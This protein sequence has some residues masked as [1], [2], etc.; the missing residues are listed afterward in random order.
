MN[1]EIL[2]QA[3]AGLSDSE[4][5]KL[6]QKVSAAR[7]SEHVA[8]IKAAFSGLVVPANVDALIDR[9]DAAGAI[10]HSGPDLAASAADQRKE[11]IEKIVAA[12]ANP[13]TQSTIALLEGLLKRGGTSIDAVVADTGLRSIKSS[14][15]R[16]F[17]RPIG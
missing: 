3:I 16:G 2:A 13:L 7:D 5:K 1:T 8:Q 17:R 10:K 12:R 6:L 14:R 15:R 4:R 9:L 11:R